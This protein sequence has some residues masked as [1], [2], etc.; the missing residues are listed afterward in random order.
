LGT[1]NGVAKF[2]GTNWMVYTW[3]NSGIPSG[4]V[5]SIAIDEIGNQWFGTT[6]GVAKFD[7]ANWTVYNTD[8]SG[9]PFDEVYSITIDS[10]G[11][12]WFG[13]SEGTAVYKEGGVVSVE[14]YFFLLPNGFKLYANYPNPF[15]PSTTI[16]Y[17]L[18]KTVNV[19]LKIYNILGQEVKMLVNETQT[20]GEKKVVWDGKD[21]LSN[22]VG[23]GIYIYQIQAGNYT[24]GRK[25]VL[26]R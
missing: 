25:L 13:T 4:E 21:H 24:K 2:D 8:N 26:L 12:K 9:L 22:D 14:E 11:N 5:W 18:P 15:N 10:N 6:K 3:I 23:S 16:R 7:R 19:L 20:A 17:D 1:G